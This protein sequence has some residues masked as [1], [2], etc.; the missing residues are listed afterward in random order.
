MITKEACYSGASTTTYAN[1]GSATGGA[2]LY[3]KMASTS[4]W[5]RGMEIS[6][7]HELDPY[8]QASKITDGCSSGTD[9]ER[10]TYLSSYQTDPGTRFF[11][12]LFFS[13][14]SPVVTLCIHCIHFFCSFVPLPP[15]FQIQMT[16]HKCTMLRFDT[17]RSS[18][19]RNGVDCHWRD[20]VHL[21]RSKCVHTTTTDHPTSN[22]LDSTQQINPPHAHLPLPLTRSLTHSFATPQKNRGTL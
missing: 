18:I 15:P 9:D 4:D 7:R 17:S 2:V 14:C 5:G 20:V 12:Y 21:S 13:C 3:G 16:R 22:L 19:T 8:I 1:T 10:P 6:L 11:L